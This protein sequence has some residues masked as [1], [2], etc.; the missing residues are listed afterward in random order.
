MQIV[1]ISE[2]N[3]EDG[4]NEAPEIV[5]G[6]DFG[7]TNSLIAIS[8]DSSAKIIKMHDGAELLPSV[9]EIIDDE[10]IIGNKATQNPDAIRSIKRLLAK[11]SKEI[12]SAYAGSAL[13][14]RLA[15]EESEPKILAKG[16]KF[17]I[18]EMASEILKYLK[19]QAEASLETDVNKAVISVPA[20]FNNT[21]R[22]QVLLAAKLA[23]FSVMR[24][25]SEPTAAAYAYGLG[26]SARGAYLVYDFGG[27][28]FD[29]TVLNMHQSVLQ[30]V[31]TGGDNMLGGD[32]IDMILAKY[33][34]K[35]TNSDLNN[36]IIALAKK[37]KEDF[38][39]KNEVALNFNS[40]N[41]V[42]SKAKYEELITPIINKTIKIAKD[43]LHEAE[44]IDLNGIILVGGSTR[45]SLIKEK[46]NKAFALPI[47]SDL[48]PD[49][50]VALGAALQAENLSSRS[51]SLLI[52]VVPLSIGLEL[53][54]GIAEKIILRN[55]PIPFSVTKEFTTHAD[56]QTGI[57]FHVVQGEREMVKDCKSL[58]KFEL[59]SL[60][61][62]K[63][64]KARIEVTFAMD[65]D[66]ILSIT[67]LDAES[68]RAQNIEIN[69]GNDLNEKEIN[70]ALSI[71]F[72][73]A[74]ADHL[75][76]LLAEARADAQSL[77]S[78]IEKAM[79]DTPDILN[80][81]EKNQIDIAISSLQKE[82]NSD[83]RDEILLKIDELNKLAAGFIQKHLDKG[84]DLLL[85]GRHIDNINSK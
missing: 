23:G 10:I 22:G 25:I 79:L 4:A 47:Y 66:G 33:I 68:G 26:K 12:K 83:N 85:K 45:V 3:S 80:E 76:R 29:V 77:I 82:I 67:A 21:Q 39:D 49:K 34:A 54:G 28:T 11:T 71:A 60:S 40:T 84:A 38:A 18:T 58:A 30:V 37:T 24:L 8:N 64:G 75:A 48:D 43:T 56:N 57:N 78:G 20:H 55:T 81:P 9:I 52:D 41:I 63:A 16:R 44:D 19:S 7:T 61:P 13:S 72:Q 62:M 65:A 14:G 1:E 5:V 59:D 15:L 74:S 73:N 53:Y 17:T 27:G 36:E 50:I 46:L 32:D 2:P 42:I 70:E 51:G 69:P 6:I 35:E 31:A